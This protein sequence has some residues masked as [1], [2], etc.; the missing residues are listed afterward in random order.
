VY[1]G[2]GLLF[3]LSF[4]VALVTFKWCHDLA[5]E[6]AWKAI[7]PDRPELEQWHPSVPGPDSGSSGG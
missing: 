2:W 7:D 5:A 3:A 6:D 1:Y 4:V